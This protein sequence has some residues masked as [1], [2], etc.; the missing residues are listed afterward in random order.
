MIHSHPLRG[1]NIPP[2]DLELI[3]VIVEVPAAWPN[4]HMHRNRGAVPHRF[5]QPCARRDASLD[6]AAAD[7]DAPGASSLCGDRRS[8]RVD[9]HLDEYLV[10]HHSSRQPNMG[11]KAG[12]EAHRPAGTQR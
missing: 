11:W 6:Q 7:F 8:D 10:V 3:G 1:V 12:S 2:H 4:H 5:H 9:T